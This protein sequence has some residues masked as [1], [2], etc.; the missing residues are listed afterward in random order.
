MLHWQDKSQL[1]R[2]KLKCTACPLIF[3]LEGL[4][5]VTSL[6]LC[7]YR[8]ELFDQNDHEASKGRVPAMLLLD[9]AYLNLQLTKVENR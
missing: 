5:A 8:N 1:W 6:C 4:K 9:P 2:L 7:P 3:E